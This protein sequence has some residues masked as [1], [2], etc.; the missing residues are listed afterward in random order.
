MFSKTHTLSK[1]IQLMIVLLILVIAFSIGLFVGRQQEARF[2]VPEGEGQLVNRSNGEQTLADDI[3]FANFWEIWNFV[4]EEYYRQPVSDEDLFYGAIKGMVSGLGDDYSVYFDPE[5]TE[6]FLEGLEGQFEGIGCEIG[7]KDAQLQVIA[8]LPET[9]ADQAGLM[10][11]DYILAVDDVLTDDLSIEES[12]MLIRGE[13]GTEVVLSIY[14][15]VSQELLEVPIIRDTITIDSVKWEMRDD[16][17]MVVGLY[18]FNHDT[19]VLF[20][21]AVQEALLN[22]AEGMVLD[23]R[24]NPGGLLTS[25]I[26]ISSY[27]TGY[28]AVVIEREVNDTHTFMGT[29][30]SRISELPTVVLVNNGSASGSEIVA[31]AL[32]DYEYAT[33]VGMQTFGKGSV[34]DFVELEDGAAIKITIAQWYTPNGRSIQEKGITPD[35]VVDYTL[36]DYESG[37]DPQLDAAISVLTYGEEETRAQYAQ[38]EEESA[39]EE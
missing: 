32:Q 28:D 37:I 22:G 36:E 29:I 14:R 19:V 24:S 2:S 9:P 34:Q 25:A 16:R 17:I 11:G 31:G 30:D 1:S 13:Q 38:Q 23:L 10:P 3:D 27:W 18:S 35:I 4:K 20:E 26:D 12:V 39:Q 33:I 5:E 7:I 21:Q 15:P 6:A 8:P